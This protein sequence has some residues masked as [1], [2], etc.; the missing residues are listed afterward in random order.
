MLNETIKIYGDDIGRVQYIQHYGNDKMIV[1]AARVSFGSDNQKPLDEKDEKLIKYLLKN[2]H[3]SPFEHCG[4]TWKFVVPLFVRGQHHRHRT[5]AYN[6]ISRR[7][8]SENVQFYLPKTFRTQHEKNRQASNNDEE[9]PLC[10]NVIGHGG[11]RSIDAYRECMAA[12]EM[13][14]KHVESSLRLYEEYLGRGITRE[15]AR[16][17]LPQNMYTEYYGTVNLHNAMH[18]L[19]LRLDEHA[20]M[21]IR[22]VAGAMLAQLVELF[23][24]AMKAFN[25]L[26]M[27]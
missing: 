14:E 17:V 7:Y 4:V 16:M 3:T 8:T 26:R 19:R 27:K 20:Q 15:M 1:N 22:V 24:V 9:N 25:E 2:H 23:P 6:E 13:L 10:T 18:F 12:D 21:E 5:W 11:G